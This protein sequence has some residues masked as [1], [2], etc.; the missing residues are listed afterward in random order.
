MN[1]RSFWRSGAACVALASTALLWCVPATLGQGTKADYERAEHL[2]QRTEHK[3]FRIGVTP[4]WFDHNH[5]FWYRIEVADKQF[6]FFIVDAESGA[7]RLAFDHAKVAAALQKATGKAQDGANLPI[8]ALEA[9]GELIR[10]NALDKG[11][12]Y[13]PAADVLGEADKLVPVIA[14]GWANILRRN[15][16]VG[17][18]ANSPD[19]KW[20]AFLKDHNVGVRR[21]EDKQE[22]LLSHEGTEADGY[23]SEFR[24]SPDSTRLVATRTQKGDDRKVYIIESSP[25]DQI[26]PKLQSYDYLKPGDKIPITKPHLFDIAGKREISIKDELFSNPWSV[27]ELRWERDSKRFTF[28]YNQRGHQVLRVVAVD[29]ESGLASAV[30]DEQSKT[31]VDYAHKEFTNYLDETDEIIWMSERDGFNHLYLYDE[32]TAQV[33]NQITRGPWV[34]RSVDRVDAKKRQIWFRAGG[35]YSEQDPYYIHYCRINFDGSGLTILT[36]GDGTHQIEY[37]PDERFFIDTYSRVDMP[38]VVELRKAEDGSLVCELEKADWLELLKVG[39]PIPERFVAKGRDGAT[40]IYG[41]IYRPSGFDPARKYPVIEK[42]YA[43]PQGSFVPKDFRAYRD[44][45][46]LAEL[47]FILVQIDGMGTSNRS[48]AFHDV[49]WKNLGDAG[50][51]DRILWMKAAAQRYSSMDITRV[52]IYG[53]SAG[54]QSSTGALLMH[55]EFYKVAVSDCG[56]HDNRMDKIWWN[57]LWMGWPVGPHYAEQSNVTNAHKLEG[58]LLLMVGELDRNVDPASTLQV[59]NALIK[60]N[61]DFDFLMI[62]GGGHG[63]GSGPYGTRRMYDYFVRNLLGVEAR[64]EK[65]E[66]SSR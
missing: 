29:A 32:K 47:G 1:D 57:E 12:R 43:G 17:S 23:D 24:W 31:F 2:R 21:I 15:W 46:S 27:T 55:P 37:S 52:G 36:R 40:D 25:K 51:A 60:A 44:V 42:I 9:S 58:K 22:Y 14:A 45:Q 54:G 39:C 30:I 34:V 28:L 11:W 5:R 10:F 64:G 59:V 16:R 18:K 63:S 62:P 48:K 19:G 66:G 20:V 7:R 41:V 13:D 53:G 49:C 33:K 56:C 6:E 50:F 3:V 38:P 26:Q 8:D 35:I 4:H 65:T 61:K